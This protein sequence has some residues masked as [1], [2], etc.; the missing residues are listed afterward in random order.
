MSDRNNNLILVVDDE[1]DIRELVRYNL[2]KSGFETLGAETGEKALELAREEH[3]ALMVLDLML[4][5]IDGLDVCRILK[6]DAR[7]EDIC[8]IMLT[9]KGEEADIVRGLEI[10]ADDYIT[11]PFSPGILTARVK[12]NVRRTTGSKSGDGVLEYG[13]LFIHKGRREVLVDGDPVDLTNTEF[14][15]LYFLA[16]NP[17][18]VFT[19]AQI[20]DEIRG[21]NYPVTDRSVDFQIVGLRKKLGAVGDCIKTVRGVGYR[22]FEDTDH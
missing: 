10:G 14:Q 20:I 21:D 1:A 9:A 5:G 16:A 3:P 15:I 18:W 17:H 12:A 8:I 13:N 11:K 19:R 7:T 2:N 6:N 22:F 4:P